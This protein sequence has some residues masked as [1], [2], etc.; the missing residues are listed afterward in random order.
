MI[1]FVVSRLNLSVFNEITKRPL[2]LVPAIV[3]FITAACLNRGFKLFRAKQ[4]ITRSRDC[5]LCWNLTHARIMKKF[6]Q[7]AAKTIKREALRIVHP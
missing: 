6:L 2:I 5:V 7:N 3:T 1:A 4:M